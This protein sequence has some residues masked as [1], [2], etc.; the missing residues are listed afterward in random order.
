MLDHRAI[1]GATPV[2]LNKQWSAASRKANQAVAQRRRDQS[3]AVTSRQSGVC[4]NCNM[5][6]S[7][8]GECNCG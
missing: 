6:R 5:M 8:S 4:R 7:A 3:R 2:E 1:A